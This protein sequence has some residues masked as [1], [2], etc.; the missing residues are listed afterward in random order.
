MLRRSKERLLRMTR[1][2]YTSSQKFLARAM[3]ITLALDAAL[4]GVNVGAARADTGYYRHIFFDNSLE[5]DAYYY[6]SGKASAPSTLALPHNKLPVESKIFFTPPNALRLQWQSEP[7]GGWE[8]QVEV[9]RFR[10]R[11]IRFDGDFL[12]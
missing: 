7:D 6:S 11:E 4:F 2:P 5:P 1:N 3:A 8:A 12:Y 10:N 9:M